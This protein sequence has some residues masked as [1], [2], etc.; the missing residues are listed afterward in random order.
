MSI[1]IGL[2]WGAFSY[3]Y[4]GEEGL[5][6]WYWAFWGI[7]LIFISGILGSMIR[8]KKHQPMNLS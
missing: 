3:L 7:P 8:F 1:L 2:I 4:F 6:T 5:Y